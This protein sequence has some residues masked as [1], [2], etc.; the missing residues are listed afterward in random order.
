MSCDNCSYVYTGIP[1]VDF[2][3]GFINPIVINVGIIVNILSVFVFYRYQNW[4][5]NGIHYLLTL[6]I[7]D[8]LTILNI[9]LINWLRSGLPII[10]GF[11]FDILSTH[12]IVCKTLMV[13]WFVTQTI[14]H[15]T[16]TFYCIERWIAI[17][18]P[19][20]SL[21][22]INKT[23][24]FKV[25]TLI[26]IFSVL[27]AIQN[28][29]VFNIDMQANGKQECFIN[30]DVSDLDRTILCLYD[31][32]SVNQIPSF[33]ALIF[34]ILIIA[35]LI[36][37][38]KDIGKDKTAQAKTEMMISVNLIIIS[39]IFILTIGQVTVI[40][41]TFYGKILNP[42]SS[43]EEVALWYKLGMLSYGIQ[44]WNYCINFFVYAWK[45]PSFRQKLKEVFS[46]GY[47]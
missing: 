8:T 41:M 4:M 21:T 29:Y 1:A 40:W 11:A 23:F 25:L 3:H 12:Q 2:Y 19:L 17:R 14:S 7:C 16:V 47:N 46:C 5:K 22:L 45:M 37:P 18:Y 34:N 32:I 30:S 33:G 24:R 26:F 44:N 35:E 39:C 10:S 36:R 6:A 15:Y 27:N 31:M 28:A 9:G 42:S 13:L 43:P 20:K 38:K